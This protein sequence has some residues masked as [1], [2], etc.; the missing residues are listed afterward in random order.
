MTPDDAFLQHI[1]ERPDDDTPR[2]VSADW[3]EDHGQPERAEFI[4]CHIEAT[5][6]PPPDTRREQLDARAAVLLQA[7]QAEWEALPP[8]VAGVARVACF[9]RGFPAWA[10]CRINDFA[11]DIAPHLPHL[12]RFAPVTKLELYDLNAEACWEPDVDFQESWISVRAYEALANLPAAQREA[13]VLQHWH[14]WSLAQIAEHLG[15]SHAAV[16]GLL[17]RG[18]Q[19]LRLQLQDRD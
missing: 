1:I 7:H 19:Q 4:R 6:L 15:R 5:R 16:A 12:W 8:E 14:G 13:L 18:L 9:E 3:L 17:K 11:E 2:L 10:R